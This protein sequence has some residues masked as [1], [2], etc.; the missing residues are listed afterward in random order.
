MVYSQVRID[1][2]KND[3]HLNNIFKKCSYVREVHCVF[4]RNNNSLMLFREI[5]AV[6]SENH[7]IYINTLRGQNEEFLDVET[8]G[9]YSFSKGKEQIV[10][11]QGGL[12]M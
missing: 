12:L 6:D 10:V 9:T 1:H 5:I 11:E 8:G 7:T 3:F 2:L 4:I